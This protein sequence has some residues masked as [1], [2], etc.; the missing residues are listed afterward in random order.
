MD[1]F[2]IE[3]ITV[4]YCFWSDAYGSYMVSC[5]PEYSTHAH[6]HTHTQDQP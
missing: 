3:E 1:N 2:K 6:T 4:T 5:N